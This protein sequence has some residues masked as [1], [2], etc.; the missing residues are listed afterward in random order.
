MQLFRRPSSLITI[1][2]IFFAACNEGPGNK[3]AYQE[4]TN[5]CSTEFIT[6]LQTV[7]FFMRNS[8]GTASERQTAESLLN[9]FGT[10]YKDV[11]CRTKKQENGKLVGAEGMFNVNEAVAT[12]KAEIKGA[13]LSNPGS[14]SVTGV[15]LTPSK[16]L[17]LKECDRKFLDE[18]NE[19]TR[20][21]LLQK[22]DDFD[23][24]YKQI[25]EF[26][27]KNANIVCEALTINALTLQ[28]EKEKFDVNSKMEEMKNV[29]KAAEKKH[30][31]KHS[32]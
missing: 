15:F 9:E 3:A 4:G 10:K 16:T 17:G 30:I 21:V 18:Y 19:M 23:L 32:V 5:L 12:A 25:D 2:I 8:S 20:N 24:M 6:D 22:I 11:N 1:P 26:K 31:L 7:S 27:K 29:L 13:P 14:M 28:T